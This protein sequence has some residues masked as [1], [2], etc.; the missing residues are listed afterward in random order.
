MKARIPIYVDLYKGIAAIVLGILLFFYPDKSSHFL[1]NMMGFFWLA[2]GLTSL[3]RDQ[4]DERYAG[5]YTARIAGIVAVLTGLLVVTRRFTSRWMSEETIFFVLGTVILAT[6]I[7]HI[8]G[9]FRIGGFKINRLT[10]VHFFLGLFEVLLGALLIF[11][12]RTETPVLYWVATAWAIVYGFLF[13]GTAVKQ[14]L[15]QRQERTGSEKEDNP[16]YE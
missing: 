5:K 14:L 16:A 10:R 4:E 11:S 2:I 7:M 1:F 8:F 12:T 13:I 9:E 3:R 6:G 15:Q